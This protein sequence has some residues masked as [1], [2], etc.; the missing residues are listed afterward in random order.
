MRFPYFEVQFSVK[1]WHGLPLDSCRPAGNLTWKPIYRGRG[2]KHA[3][4]T[5]DIKSDYLV[6]PLMLVWYCFKEQNQNQFFEV[7]TKNT[8]KIA[9][10]APQRLFEENKASSRIKSFHHFSSSKLWVVRSIYFSMQNIFIILNLSKN[11][12][13][14]WNPFLVELK[15]LPWVV[16]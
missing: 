4:I 2:C 16:K 11:S 8:P 1:T 5:R 9:T 6:F 15:V 3:T 12:D 10:A 7:E 14:F 13:S